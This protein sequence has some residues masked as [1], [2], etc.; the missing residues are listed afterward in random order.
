MIKYF[1]ILFIVVLLTACNQSVDIEYPETDQDNFLAQTTPL[2]DVSKQT[3]EGV[4]EVLNGND[5]FGDQ[6][7]LKWS[8][9]LLS[10]F[11]N[12]DVGFMVMEGGSLDSII[13]FKGYWRY[14]VNTETGLMDFNIT[15]LEGGRNILSGDTSNLQITIR[16]LFGND[17]NSPNQEFVIKYLRPFSEKVK[18]QDFYILAHRGGGRNS[19][20]LPA[21]ENSIEMISLAERLGANGIEIDVKLTSDDVPI[22]YHD[23]DINLRLTQK[24]VIWGNIEDFTFAQL[25]TFVK[26][27]HG[28]KIPSL[29]EALTFVLENTQ[30]KFVWLDLKSDKNEI[31]AVIEIQEKILK[32]AHSSNRDLQIVLGIP[33][34][35]KASS[36]MQ[37]PSYEE[38]PSLCEL[39]TDYVRQLNSLYW[40]PRWTLGTQIAS[41]ETMHSEGRNA[42]VWTLDEPVFVETFI[43]DGAFD[44][45]LT[46]YPALVAYYHYTRQ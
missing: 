9:D 42:F 24:S 23:P 1:S 37:Y 18:Q 7:V 33:A 32:K 10:V 30:L 35:E 17:S 3:M 19:D 20:Y 26:L 41:V 4:Y 14:E 8:G 28:E 36:L 22:L 2:S 21:S 31:P 5:Y 12:K 11:T 45:I 15:S 38:I 25:R 44:G 16:G 27:I 39:T 6:V 13:Y 46:N 43:R 29:E 40:A 34:E